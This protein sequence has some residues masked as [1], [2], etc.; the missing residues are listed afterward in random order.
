MKLRYALALAFLVVLVSSCGLGTS[1]TTQSSPTTQADVT[2][3]TVQSTTTN[4][5]T[6]TIAEATTT[7][8]APANLIRVE[9]GVKV[10][11]PDTISVTQGEVVRFQV[12][13]DVADEVHVHGYDLFFESIPGEPVL[14][15]FNADATGIFEVELEGGHLGLVN[16]EVTP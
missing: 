1:P 15:E 12:V 3:T 8:I 16:I 13:A 6:T 4:V 2:T 5:A 14:V 7:T 11:G 9:G 10:E